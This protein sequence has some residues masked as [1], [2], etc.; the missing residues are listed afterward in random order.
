MCNIHFCIT[1]PRHIYS[2]SQVNN[3]LRL[4]KSHMKCGVNLIT[5]TMTTYARTMI[6]YVN[7][8]NNKHTLAELEVFHLLFSQK[9]CETCRYNIRKFACS[10]LM[11]FFLR[12]VLTYPPVNLFY[13]RLL[14]H[15]FIRMSH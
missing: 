15:Y 9:L 13:K 10:H 2:L 5:E 7:A 1:Y 11:H 14:Y 12:Y 8:H 3:S 4:G 6:S